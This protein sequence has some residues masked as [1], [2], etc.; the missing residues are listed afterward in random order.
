MIKKGNRVICY[1][2]SEEEAN[3]EKKLIDLVMKKAVVDKETWLKFDVTVL[4]KF[5]K[6]TNKLLL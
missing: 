6:T 2:P 4:A 1:W 5:G 3:N